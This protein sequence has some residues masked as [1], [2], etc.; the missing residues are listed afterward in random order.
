[1]FNGRYRLDGF[2]AR[3]ARV[4]R[5]LQAGMIAHNQASYFDAD[6]P[7]GGYKHSGMGRENGE[8]GFHDATQIKVASAEQN[9]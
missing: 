8:A 4:A 6:L 2:S 5:A 7:F 9:A 1:M 3:F